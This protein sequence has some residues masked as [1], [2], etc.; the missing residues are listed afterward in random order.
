[1]RLYKGGF[2]AGGVDFTYTV[3]LDARTDQLTKKISSFQESLANR[4]LD[5][6][7][8]FPGLK[9]QGA[10]KSAL[11]S[12]GVSMDNIKKVT[13]ETITLTDKQGNAYNEAKK[14][15]V[16]YRD[17]FGKMATAFINVDNQTASTTKKQKEYDAV[18]KATEKTLNSTQHIQ[19]KQREA[20]VATANELNS[21]IGEWKELAATHQAD[22]PRA[23]ELE[24]RTRS[25][26]DSLKQQ[27]GATKTGAA[28]L[29]NFATTMQRAIKQSFAYAIA[30]R[31][32]RLAQQEL[33]N[34]IRYTID[35]DTE[36]TK[37]Q[38]LQ[39]EGAKTA[40]E[41]N[42]LADAFNRLAQEMGSSTLEVARGSVEWFN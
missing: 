33:N 20:I 40:Y 38:V 6:K 24:T 8:D 30:M 34:A 31:A 28:G 16:Q 25:L 41:I 15:V 29:Q 4:P 1:M 7:I 18:L 14:L 11:D 26:T 21:V 19:G 5:V 37:I 27:E 9:N 42:N 2:M 13:T 10:I 23:K 12:L 17:E 22:S 36:M 3:G 32:I 39:V 35:L